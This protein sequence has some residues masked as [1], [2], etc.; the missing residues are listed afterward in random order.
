MPLPKIPG[1]PGI[2]PVPR[3]PTGGSM[4]GKKK[5]ELDSNAL[6]KIAAEEGLQ[7]QADA[8]LEGRG[9]TDEFMSG[10]WVMDTLDIL[11][12]VDYG[13]IGVLQGKTFTEGI[14]TR[15]SFADK[16]H[17][18][19]YGLM[20]TIA[21]IVA[22][23]AVTAPIW[24]VASPFKIL[25]A[26]GITKKVSKAAKA[27]FGLTKKVK[28]GGLEKIVPNVPTNIISKGGQWF[29]SKVLGSIAADPSYGRAYK[30]AM[31][32]KSEA[33]RKV[34][35]AARVWTDI[36]DN[37]AAKIPL[38]FVRNADGSLGRTAMEN[39]PRIFDG[40]ELASAQK[41]W[42]ISEGVDEAAYAL[43]MTKSRNASYMANM[44]TQH[45]SEKGMKS[46][47]LKRMRTA[48]P[49]FMQR[50]LIYKTPQEIEEQIANFYTKFA[51][52]HAKGLANP[53]TKDD[54]L[55]RAFK[56]EKKIRDRAMRNRAA[57]RKVRADLGEIKDSMFPVVAGLTRAINDIENA[58][59]F[60]ALAKTHGMTAELAE[61]LGIDLSKGYTLLQGGK[62][63]KVGAKGS[64][65]GAL[66][67]MFV[68]NHIADEINE[69]VR[70]KSLLENALGAGWG[71]FKWGKTAG[72]PAG[73]ARNVMSNQVLN[74]WKLGMVPGAPSTLK[75]QGLAA[76]EMAKGG[77]Y[78]DEARQLG[79]NVNTFISAELKHMFNGPDFA[80]AQKG[81]T[82]G[83]KRMAKKF[84]KKTSEIYQASENHAKLSAYI[85]NRTTKGMGKAKAW[86]MAEAATF[87]YNAVGPIVR[88]MRESIWGVPFLTFGIKA[89]PLAAE[90]ALKA[91]HRISFIGKIKNAIEKMSDT[92]ETARERAAEPPWIR[93]GLFVKLPMKDK[94]GRSAYFDLTYI[95]PF[96]DLVS[97]QF[98]SRQI[99]RETGLKESAIE[100]AMR[101][102]PVINLITELGKNQDFYG[103][104]IWKESD[105]TES[106]IA[107]ITRHITKMWMPPPIAEQIPG[108]YT[109]KGT[110]QGKRRP[111]MF[112]RISLA[113]EKRLYRTGMQELMR[114]MG[115]KIQPINADVQETYQEYE[116]RRALTTLLGE[117]AVVKEF[118]RTIR[119]KKQ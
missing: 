64:K 95:V 25:S 29:R 15:A 106:Q 85:Y 99:N 31:A 119:T 58:K 23:V 93:D 48:G 72:N 12:V 2:E 11:N 65:L 90:T 56:G 76:R 26:L 14:K 40:D 68:P 33:M 57:V 116:K 66:S 53:K 105:S 104:K 79:Y 44:Y 60:Q 8:A 108:G 82:A 96:G 32:S 97:G 13:W 37:I 91:P 46:L 113:D 5:G 20:G 94:H 43:G 34:M 92:E 73:Q 71:F 24:M 77:K 10:G 3:I 42:Q 6:Y 117:H 4:W 84:M 102:A 9:E 111:G 39:L 35:G 86:A 47:G 28:K 109:T 21:G 70:S 89:A 1:I 69:M 83:A 110:R 7:E 50:K 41:L 98:F 52:K 75:A 115:I 80:A 59:L 118:Q 78:I 38:A 67:G 107:D 17:L 36:D 114:N 63:G 30:G 27:A 81:F 61:Q 74:W 103:N 112:K 88:R 49:A 101:K 45:L 19:K 87:D 16:D 22:D 55:M 18:G 54:L 62:F 51:K 100:A